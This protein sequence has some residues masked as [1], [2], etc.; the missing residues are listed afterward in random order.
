MTGLH[1]A[2]QSISLIKKASGENQNLLAQKNIKLPD[3]KLKRQS[4]NS[5]PL[6][7]PKENLPVTI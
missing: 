4:G 1:S 5:S 3:N 7:M 2:A 6:L